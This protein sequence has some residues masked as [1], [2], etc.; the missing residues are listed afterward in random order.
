M[1]GTAVNII[2]TTLTRNV[3]STFYLLRTSGLKDIARRKVPLP[4]KS[5]SAGDLIKRTVT[6]V[7]HG[8]F[9]TAELLRHWYG[10][11]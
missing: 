7:P 11:E 10:E 2:K 8:V 3:K 9:L 1:G 4:V 6:A 5:W